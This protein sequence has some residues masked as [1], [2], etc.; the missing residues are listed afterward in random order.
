M[1]T[2]QFRFSITY[3]QADDAS[4]DGAV[5][6]MFEEGN[7]TVSLVADVDG[8]LDAVGD[9]VMTGQIALGDDFG[10]DTVQVRLVRT[11]E[12]TMRI[13][14]RIYAE[15]VVRDVTYPE[16]YYESYGNRLFNESVI[17]DVPLNF[18]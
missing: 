12:T 17:E 11:S 5:E 8:R 13:V 7:E 9:A 10:A 15:F 3:G 16:F 6:I 1:S 14:F 18:S 2:D 4:T